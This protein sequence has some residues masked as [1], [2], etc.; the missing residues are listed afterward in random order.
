[1]KIN[2]SQLITRAMKKTKHGKE[3]SKKRVNR[4]G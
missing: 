3:Y 2:S 4:V 1:M